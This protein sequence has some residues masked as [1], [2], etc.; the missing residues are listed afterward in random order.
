[1]SLTSDQK[2]DLLL[3]RLDSVLRLQALQTVSGMNAGEAAVLLDIAGLDR[4]LIATILDTTQAS[5]RKSI[6][7]AKKSESPNGRK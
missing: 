4:R 3:D 7:R 2:F 6:S 1:M 5:V